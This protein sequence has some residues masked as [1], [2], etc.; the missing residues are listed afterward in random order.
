[1]V[2]SYTVQIL[3][4]VVSIA[5]AAAEE[6]SG[7]GEVTNM[8]CIHILAL[9]W[10]WEGVSFNMQQE[11]WRTVPGLNQTAHKNIFLILQI[12]VLDKQ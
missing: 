5:S 9:I 6:T 2:F 11:Q 7:K 4:I 10:C 12:I 8:M 1:M 3:V